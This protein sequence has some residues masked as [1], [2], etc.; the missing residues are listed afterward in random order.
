[1]ADTWQPNALHV[2]GVGSGPVSQLVAAALSDDGATMVIRIVNQLPVNLV[3]AFCGAH[4]L[5]AF[6]DL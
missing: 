3:R 5:H 2:A 1:V 4:V 6:L